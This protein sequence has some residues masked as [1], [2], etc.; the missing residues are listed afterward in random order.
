[1]S[2][3][4]FQTLEFF[5]SISAFL[6]GW[7]L[8][9]P[10]LITG[11]LFTIRL[12]GIQITGLGKAL[13][14]A[15]FE[16]KHKDTEGEGD[17]S[18]FK[19]L[20]TA[21]S[22]TV[23]T[24]NIAGVATAVTLGGP[25]ALFWMWVTGFFGMATKY[26][27]SVLGV[28]YREKHENGEFSGGPMYY[29]QNGLGKKW[30]WL[31]VFFSIS[32]AI[33]ALGIGN[34]V[35]SNSM[36]DVMET[37]FGV[38]R[39]LTGT[40]VAVFAGLVVV[41]GIKRIAD[42]ASKIVPVMIVIY[43]VTGSTIL[44]M[45]YDLIPA[46]F[47]LIFDNAFTSITALAGGVIGDAVSKGVGR[48]VFS[49]ESGMGSAPIIAAAAK[50]DHPVSQALVSMTQ[51]LID[52]L[53][54][55]SFTGLIIIMSGM[56]SGEIEG[57]SLT[58]SAFSSGLHHIMFMGYEVGELII[59]I[60]L[61]FFVFST[62]IGW[63]Y[64]GEK[65]VEFILG[66]KSVRFYKALFIACSLLG[67]L[68]TLE[69]AWTISEVFTALMILPNLIALILLSNKVHQLTRDYFKNNATKKYIVKPFYND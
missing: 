37:T 35:Q 10:L 59:S 27:E 46:V 69:L 65:G 32:L 14:L 24:G 9:L 42:V 21:L 31:A 44:I 41:G 33:A 51:T 68:M 49:N 38:D 16:K 63:Y 22:A 29:I 28:H 66:Y 60:T 7:P 61:V 57:A 11:V 50:T 2:D 18:H 5:K 13:H 48:G 56:S 8:L 6:W 52:T 17:I 67:A 55:C 45:N 54:I 47:E 40:V 15:F 1:M 19:A 25:G 39:W 4:E 34:M 53:I 23:G 64:Y 62:I 20:M 3:I 26:A 58:A 30:H 36:A 43:V 12:K